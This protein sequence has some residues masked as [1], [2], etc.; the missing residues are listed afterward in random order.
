MCDPKPGPRCSAH[1][2]QELKAAAHRLGAA[3]AELE[4]FPEDR[5]S[6]RRAAQAKENYQAKLAAYDSSPRGQRDLQNEIIASPDPD[7]AEVD[8]LRTRL[9]IGRATRIEQKRALARAKGLSAEEE[10]LDVAKA[11]RRL[12]HPDGGYTRDPRTGREVGMGFFVSPYPGRERPVPAESLSFRDVRGFARDNADLLARDG[13]YEGAWHDP[14]TGIVSLD[15]S[16]RVESA[17]AARRLCLDHQQAAF[18]DPQM[19]SSVNVTHSG[20]RERIAAQ[21]EGN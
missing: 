21:I 17:E 15:V 14:E 10:N 7:S 20:G 8:P 1:T 2:A 5:S 3:E 12:R 9:Y 4:R 13:H 16:I 18:Y 6:R 11:L 19:G